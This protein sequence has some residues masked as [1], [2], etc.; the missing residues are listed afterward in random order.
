MEEFPHGILAAWSFP[1]WPAIGLVI[2][3][4]LYV[5]GWRALQRTRARDLP[6]WRAACFLGGL[7]AIWIALASPIDALDDFLLSAHM[8]QHFILMSI[9]PPLLVLGAPLVPMLRGLP[10]GL[11]RWFRPVFASRGVHKVA[12]AMAHPAVA[13]L[14]MNVAYLGWHVPQAFELTLRSEA[15]HNTEHMCFLFT[16]IAFWWVIVEPWPSRSRWSQW[17]VIPYLLTADVVNTILSAVLTFS[18]KVLYPSYAAAE[19]ISSLSP[20]K[21]QVLAGAEMW[22]LNSMVFL[23]PVAVLV[24]RML[25]PRGLRDASAMTDY[26]GS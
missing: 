15:W 21:D 17:M 23:V 24:V 11:I 25:S 26:A 12:H 10:R 18:G 5:R 22:V 16:S 9:A 4:T 14:V 20:L 1:V 6:L 8:L 19:R 2:A 3:G 13:W 7:L